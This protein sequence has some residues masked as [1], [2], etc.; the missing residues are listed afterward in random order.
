MTGLSIHEQVRVQ[1]PAPRVWLALTTPIEL[2]EWYAPGC[3]WE[4]EGLTPGA[5]ARFYNTE[6]DIQTATV[7]AAVAPHQLSLR[8]HADPT[9]PSAPILNT[10]TLA[11]D[12]D[13]TVVT[14]VQSGYE[15]VPDAVRE[16]WLEQDRG[17]VA[18]IAASLKAY[19]ER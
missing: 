15:A 8:W 5:T 19:V 4:I 1:A 7:E 12:G 2:Y 14:I 9:Q 3:R 16:R 13:T 6:T 11:P 10:F 17:A 18:A